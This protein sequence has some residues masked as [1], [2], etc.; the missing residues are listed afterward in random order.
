VLW[1]QDGTV[2][3]S[4]PAWCAA[5]FTL[6]QRHGGHWT[7][8]DAMNLVGS[9]LNRTAA[10]LRA[11]GVNLEIEALINAL[12][13]LVIE[14]VMDTNPWREGIIEALA[15]CRA[16]GL[17]CALVSMS[18]RRFTHAV[19]GLLP[20]TFDAVVSG[21]EVTKGKPDPEPYL[22]GA[23]RLGLPVDCCIAVEDSP[24]GVASA[25]AAGLPVVVVPGAVDVPLVPGLV[26][27]SSAKAITVDWLRQVHSQ[28]AADR[29]S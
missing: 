4:E 23:A 25:L 2:I 17:R 21:D 3:D 19:A 12:T 8:A 15:D 16:A 22:I 24:T 28:L 13:D 11:A 18:W 6:V 14:Q 10:A 27:V 9:D 29:L 7:Q 26:K 1:D 20:G 5:E